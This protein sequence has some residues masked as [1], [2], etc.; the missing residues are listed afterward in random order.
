MA[1]VPCV[2][3]HCSHQAVLCPRALDYALPCKSQGLVVLAYFHGTSS[4]LVSGFSKLSFMC[5]GG[6]VLLKPK[7]WEGGALARTKGP[8]ILAPA[9]F[10]SSWVDLGKLFL[11]CAQGGALPVE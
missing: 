5:E 9:L 7:P 6:A 4:M 1:P 11:T 2:F 8:R 10:Q 3:S